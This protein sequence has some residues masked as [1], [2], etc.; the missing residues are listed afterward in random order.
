MKILPQAAYVFAKAPLGLSKRRSLHQN[1]RVRHVLA[2]N[3]AGVGA[4]SRR[5]LW[6]AD[7]E[8]ADFRAVA[9]FLASLSQ[10]LKIVVIG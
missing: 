7:T 3:Q 2:Y 1:A 10:D 5:K 8:A 4:S 9:D 6:E